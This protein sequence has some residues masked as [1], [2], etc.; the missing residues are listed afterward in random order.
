[1]TYQFVPLSATDYLNVHIWLSH[2]ANLSAVIDVNKLLVAHKN[3]FHEGGKTV[4]NCSQYQP[5]SDRYH[6]HQS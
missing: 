6:Q 2:D 3:I 5:G 1:M 4:I